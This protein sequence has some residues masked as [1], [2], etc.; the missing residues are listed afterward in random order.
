MVITRSGK[1]TESQME[2]YKDLLLS[3]I[4][5]QSQRLSEL[6]KTSKIYSSD[7]T[8][9][10]KPCT[11]AGGKGSGKVPRWTFGEKSKLSSRD[12]DGSSSCKSDRS[13]KLSPSTPVFSVKSGENVKEWLVVV[14]AAIATANIPDEVALPCI[15]PFVKGRALHSVIKYMSSDDAKNFEG[16]LEAFKKEFEPPD[17]QRKLKLQL[18]DLKQTDS[19]DKFVEKFLTI[20]NQIDEIS[21]EDKI[22]Y[23]GEGLHTRSRLEVLRSRPKTLD[24]AI[25]I[26]S[27]T[28]DVLKTVQQQTNAVKKV[29]RY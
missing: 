20:C 22:M 25:I 27:T 5:E 26:A 2:K 19:F 28:E 13:Y 23:F 7:D 3:V 10:S 21:E 16:F 15:L 4:Q 24:D 17:Y 9:E 8:A 1:D 12:E 6:E 29:K 14:S 18:R 11:S